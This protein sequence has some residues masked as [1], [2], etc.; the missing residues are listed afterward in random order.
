MKDIEQLVTMGRELEAYPYYGARYAL[1]AAQ[2]SP[3]CVNVHTECVVYAIGMVN[4][5]FCEMFIIIYFFSIT[6]IPCF[7]LAISF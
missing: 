1:P 7:T 4:L 2:V 3:Y 6:I 5:W